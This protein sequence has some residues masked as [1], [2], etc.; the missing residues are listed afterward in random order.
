MLK[1]FGETCRY[2]TGEEHEAR[3]Y[4]ISWKKFLMRRLSHDSFSAEIVDEQWIYRDAYLNGCMNEMK[5]M[6]LKL[7]LNGTWNYE[8]RM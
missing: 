5:I 1:Y 3:S 8:L 7:A 6:S 4:L 2:L